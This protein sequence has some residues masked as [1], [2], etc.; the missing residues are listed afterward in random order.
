[1][2]IYARYL[3]YQTWKLRDREVKQLTPSHTAVKGRVRVRSRLLLAQCSHRVPLSRMAALMGIL[4]DRDKLSRFQTKIY[5][6]KNLLNTRHWIRFIW[7][8]NILV[9]LEQQ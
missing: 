2:R 3:T 5:L 8:P 6:P 7:G 4:G 1:M 9:L